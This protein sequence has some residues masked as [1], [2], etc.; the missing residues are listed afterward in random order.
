MLTLAGRNGAND[1]QT[2]PETGDQVTIAEQTEQT[3]Q[4]EMFPQPPKTRLQIAEEFVEHF[5]GDVESAEKSL[6]NARIKLK[7]A[8]ELRDD[9][10][11]NLRKERIAAGVATAEE[12]LV[13]MKRTAE[14]EG[15]GIS[16]QFNDEPVVLAEPPE[17]SC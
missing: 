4:A 14:Q 6:V 11:E 17:A 10:E 9:A 16:F 1:S 12:I 2:I 13:D 8:R 5:Q 15:Y 7:A 3:T